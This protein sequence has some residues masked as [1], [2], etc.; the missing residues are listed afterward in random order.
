MMPFC[1]AVAEKHADGVYV[2]YTGCS[3]AAPHVHYASE[4]YSGPP[5]RQPDITVVQAEWQPYESTSYDESQDH[6]G[7]IPDGGCCHALP[8]LSDTLGRY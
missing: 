1:D 3:A 7:W 2:I 4:P 6:D 5:Y 8:S